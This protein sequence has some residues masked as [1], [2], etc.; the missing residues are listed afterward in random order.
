MLGH[1]HH[2]LFLVVTRFNYLVTVILLAV[3]LQMENAC[4]PYFLDT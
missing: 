2:L 1:Y 3:V 4:S